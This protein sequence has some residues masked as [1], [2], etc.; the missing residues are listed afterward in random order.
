MLGKTLQRFAVGTMALAASVALA[1]PA[2]EAPAA[3]KVGSELT[4]TVSGTSNPRD[5]VTIVPKTQQEGSYLGYVYVEK[6]GSLKLAMPAVAGDYEL[7]LL[8]ANSPYPTLVKRAIKLEAV[9]ATLSFPAQVASGAQFQVTWTGPKNA[10]DYVAIGTAQQKYTTYKYVSEG[11]PVTLQAPDA[12]G[13]YQIRYIL[14]MNDTVIAEQ[15]LT[16]GAVSAS[17][18]VPTSVGVG[19][20]FKIQWTG[21]NNPRDFITVVKAGTPEKQYNAYAYTSAGNPA[22]LRAP[23]QAGDYEI[24]YLTGQSYA[25]LATAK[26]AVTAANATVKGPATAVAGSAFAVTWTG[27]NNQRDFI[28][29]VPKGAREGDSGSWAYTTNGSPAQM[30]APLNPGEYELRYSLGQSYATLARTSIQIT[31]G[32]EEPGFVVVTPPTVAST[33]N[34]IEIVFDASGSMLQKLGT[35]RRIEIARE[36]LTRLTSQVIPAGTPFAMRVF[37]REVNSCQTDLFIPVSPLN[38]A[39]VAGQIA[40]LDAKNGAKT[41]IGASLA[42]AAEDLRSVKGEK[43]IVL[44]TDGEETCDGDPAAEIEKL[45]KSG[46][47]L[48]VSIVGFAIDEPN[49]AVTFRQW[50]KAGNGAFFEANDAAGLSNALA[51]AMRPGF[52][53]LD[54]KGQ[55]VAE[56][57]TGPDKVKVLP[58]TYTVRLK[59]QKSAAKPV[60]VKQKETATVGF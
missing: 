6:G 49:L 11:N 47:G 37:G 24:R 35:K 25:T 60:T 29:L 15:P 16:V 52:E 55:V 43:L 19:A 27:P 1:A 57:V 42:K 46:L 26:I 31:P 28:N 23:E 20:N 58:G 53:V 17:V 14:A 21:P 3:A 30:Q 2:L 41:P 5:F 33:D 50:A 38:A 22:E 40:K 13:T 34:A 36:T 18:T 7:R 9:S 51:Q 56:G 12:A 45:Q 54:A 39:T 59:G 48:R 10:R 8:S 4:F 44:L 32:K